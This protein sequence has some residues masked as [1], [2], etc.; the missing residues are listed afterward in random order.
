MRKLDKTLLEKKVVGRIIRDIDEANIA[1]ARVIVAQGGEILLD[2]AY[3]YS[4]ITAGVPLRSGAMFRLASIT[5]PVAGFA[6]LLGMQK[7]YFGYNDLLS[8]HMPEFSELYVGRVENGKAVPDHPAKNPIRIHMLLSHS[9]GFACSSEV[10]TVMAEAAPRSAY[11]SRRAYIDYALSGPLGFEPG[12][13]Y[14]YSQTAAFDVVAQL[15]EKYSGMPYHEFVNK[16]V[17]EPLG[18]KDIT[19]F[20][21]EEQW[22]RTVAVSDRLFGGKMISYHIGKTIFEGFPL[23]YA[24]AGAGLLGSAEDYFKF[25]EMLR[26]RGE[27]RGVRLV[28]EELFSLYTRH[29]ADIKYRGAGADGTW[30]L[31]VYVRVDGARLPAGSFGWSGAYGTHFF[32]DPENDITAIYMK[33]NRWHDS[34]GAGRTGANF[35][36]DVTAS[37]R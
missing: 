33:N 2:G 18:I 27:Y 28:D 37:L 34:H 8:E 20:P 13:G 25:A 1:G 9:S 6:F 22:A 7:G 12:E 14:G 16:N 19:Y 30:G 29:S 35:E 31:G 32:V 11:A 3:G 10:E 17:F 5:K 26:C 24:A 36:I 4:D 23:E 15:I 21:T